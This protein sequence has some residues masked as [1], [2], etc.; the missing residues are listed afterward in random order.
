LHTA[1]V[2][3]SNGFIGK[4]LCQLLVSKGLHVYGISRS[5]PSSDLSP[6]ISTFTANLANTSFNSFIPNFLTPDYVVHLAGGSSVGASIADP[7]AD[8]SNT[9]NS[10]YQL[11]EWVKSKCPKAR[12]IL[13][14]SAAVYGNNYSVPVVESS[15]RLPYSPYGLHKCMLEDL[16]HFYT[17]QYDLDITVVRLFSVFG[18]FLRKQLIWDVCQKLLRA[19]DHKILLSGTG[20]EVRDWSHVDQVN[21]S[22]YRLFSC[23]NDVPPVINIASGISL[24]VQEFLHIIVT[25]WSY[26]TGNSIS[27]EFDGKSRPADP[28]CLAADV[29]LA[30]SLG[31]SYSTDLSRDVLQYIK[32]FLSVKYDGTLPD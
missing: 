23:P 28:S 6:E 1:I 7:L 29:T 16:G 14:S 5:S 24:T 20:S 3:G 27:V 9:V 30:N 31:M 11:L 15:P 4:N 8:F 25:Q 13:I 12:V 32:W 22:I 19:V 18:P 21:T 2:T 26:L 17:S 10:A